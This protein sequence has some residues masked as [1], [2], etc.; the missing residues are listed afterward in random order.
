MDGGGL[1]PQLLDL[2]DL[3]FF[4]TRGLIQLLHV[5]VGHLLDLVVRA[6]FVVFGDGFI[7]EKLFHRFVAVTPDVADRDTVIFGDS[8]ELLDQILARFTRM[9]TFP[10]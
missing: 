9:V 4:G 2:D 10:E 3:F 1:D 5:G 6:A 8:M 7:F